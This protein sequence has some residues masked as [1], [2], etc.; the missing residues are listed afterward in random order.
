M[1]TAQP[2]CAA[3]AETLEH[4]ARHI[5]QL[6]DLLEAERT[7]L[8]GAPND[9]VQRIAA[10]KLVR[11]QALDTYAARRAALLTES[12]YARS[13]DGMNG[14]IAASGPLRARMQKLWAQVVVSAATARDL[15]ELNGAL[16]RT[17]LTSVQD[18]LARLQQPIG[19][20]SALYGADGL[21]H[22]GGISRPL[23]NV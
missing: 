16:I 15:N 21:A 18:R 7:A 19:N 9:D 13:A 23:G 10:E 3:L 11:I 17:R 4:E 1:T 8:V 5:A 20:P 12:G 22:A 14:A 6:I 2:P